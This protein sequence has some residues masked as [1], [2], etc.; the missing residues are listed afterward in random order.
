MAVQMSLRKY[1]QMRGVS[2]TAVQK[3]IKRLGIPQDAEG[4]IDVAAAERLWPREGATPPATAA[5]MPLQP[6]EPDSISFAE[7]KRRKEL[8]L[9]QLRELEVAEK[10]GEM[11]PL[12]QH[13]QRLQSICERLAARVKGLGRYMG[14]VQRATTD[15]EAAELLERIS[16]D[17]LR[18]LMDLADEIEEDG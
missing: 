2:R 7:A 18:S 14:D 13:E 16:D 9:A 4:Q 8:A 17:L 10:E 1:A 5:A 3:A 15:I 12:S 6:G 11:L